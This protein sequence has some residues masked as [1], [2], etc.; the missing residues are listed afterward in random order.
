YL[1]V[2]G[3][4]RVGEPA[5]DL[6]VAAALV[7]ALTESPVPVDT[8]V[9]GEIGLSGRVRPVSHSDARLKE[10][11]KLGFGEAWVPARVRARGERSGDGI[12]TVAIGHLSELVDRLAPSRSRRPPARRIGAMP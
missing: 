12:A 7:S 2:A 1:N 4:L 8:V 9:F 11:A 10:A 3:G 5:A 6:A